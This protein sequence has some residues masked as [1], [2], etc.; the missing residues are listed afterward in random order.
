LA[1]KR[2]RWDRTKGVPEPIRALEAI[3]EEEAGEPLV[4]LARYAPSVRLRRPQLIP[5]ARRTVA[6]MV[7]AAA[8][9]LPPGIFLEVTDAWRPLSRQRLIHEWMSQCALEVF[10]NLTHAALRRKVNRWVAPFDSKAPPGHCTGGA[11]DV[12]LVDEQGEPLDISSPYT[13]FQAAPTYSLGLSE[14]AQRNREML[15]SAMLEAG[16][17]NCRDE[18]WHYSYGDAAWAVR[19]RGE[20]CFYGLVELPEELYSEQQAAWL[21]ALAERTNPFLEEV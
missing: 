8:R 6:E 13:R 3:R 10:P 21:R 11:L 16:F 1:A 7:E 12:V 4:E 20:T 18:W 2:A 17:S 19:T 9:S 15:V 5:W 14:V